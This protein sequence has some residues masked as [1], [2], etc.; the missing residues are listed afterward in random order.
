MSD[1]PNQLQAALGG[2]YDF[3]RQMAVRPH[4]VPLLGVEPNPSKG[5]EL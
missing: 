4:G 3:R 1:L 2:R 5:S